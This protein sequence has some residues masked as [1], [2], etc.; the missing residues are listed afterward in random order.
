MNSPIDGN[1]LKVATLIHSGSEH[2]HKCTY[3]MEEV[4]TNGPIS[5]SW[6]IYPDSTGISLKCNVKALLKLNCTR[7]L[8][9]FEVPIA[10]ELSESLMLSR[11]NEATGKEKE[12]LGDDFFETVDENGT[13]DLK[14]FVRQFLVMETE[15][16]DYCDREDC[17]FEQDIH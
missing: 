8:E 16:H 9:P 12:L 1:T 17:S 7:C 4:P 5:C 2:R 14:D 13:L 10:L 15:N 3:E 11:F 6:L